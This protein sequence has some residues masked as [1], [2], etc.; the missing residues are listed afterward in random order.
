MRSA[1]DDGRIAV[2]DLADERSRRSA[3][4]CAREH[5]DVRAHARIVSGNVALRIERQIRVSGR[6][7]LR[8][9]SR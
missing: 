4:V 5:G 1:S 8:D 2:V 3:D 7:A 9:R 6:H